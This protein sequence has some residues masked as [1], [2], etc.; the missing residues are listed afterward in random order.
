M[1]SGCPQGL[2]SVLQGRR[3]EESSLETRSLKHVLKHPG[4]CGE[5]PCIS[6]EELGKEMVTKT[7]AWSS[8]SCVG[9]R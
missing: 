3:A 7:E 2:C 9:S 1:R 6:E 5:R 8:L 4:S